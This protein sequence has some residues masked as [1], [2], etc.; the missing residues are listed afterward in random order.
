MLT[1]GKGG[2]DLPCGTF[3]A[4]SITI[5]GSS[6]SNRGTGTAFKALQT[7][8]AGREG[9]PHRPT[10]RSPAEERAWRWLTRAAPQERV[11]DS[12][13]AGMEPA[14]LRG[15]GREGRRA[16]PTRPG[17]EPAGPSK[18]GAIEK[19]L[20]ARKLRVLRERPQNAAVAR[21]TGAHA[22]R[23]V[24]DVT[25]AGGGGEGDGA[26]VAP[27]VGDPH[28]RQPAAVE[29]R[30]AGEARRNGENDAAAAAAA[31]S[32]GG[33]RAGAAGSS[34]E[35]VA[36]ASAEEEGAARMLQRHARGFVGRR[37]F[38][39][40]R[41]ELLRRFWRERTLAD[42]LGAWHAVAARRAHIRRR[43]RQL[44]LYYGRYAYR[45]LAESFEGASIFAAEGKNAMADRYCEWRRQ[46]AVLF[47]WLLAASAK[48][49]AA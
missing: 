15:G 28:H 31:D 24:D 27:A 34:E 4:A 17:T 5:R 32:G 13:F 3:R 35:P 36:S 8:A 30:V 11:I 39:A 18:F 20:A 10:P 33:P 14:R 46:S 38:Q 19:A 26:A 21:P 29:A 43:L 48:G 25:G 42:L 9:P 22:I 7:A 49:G 40:R 2:R 41:V 47:A 16:A 6:S 45:H 23:N 37:R 12:L 1:W 44:Q